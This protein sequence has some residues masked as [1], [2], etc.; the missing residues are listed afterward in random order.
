MPN[1]K[2]QVNPINPTSRTFSLNG[3]IGDVPF[4][5]AEAFLKANPTAK[6][7]VSFNL[8]GKIGDVPKENAWEFMKANQTAK[9]IFY[10]LTGKKPVKPSDISTFAPKRTNLVTPIKSEEVPQEVKP[11]KVTPEMEAFVEKNLPKTQAINRL[12]DSLFIQF[13]YMPVLYKYWVLIFVKG[14]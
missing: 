5:N 3:V 7:M 11:A 13:G 6:E 12:I 4:E 2:E 9:P 14:Q 10:D 1:D 8:N